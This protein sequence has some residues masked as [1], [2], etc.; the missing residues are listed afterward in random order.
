[1]DKLIASQ[2]MMQEGILVDR[3]LA[4]LE[5]IHEYLTA[6]VAK[7]VAAVAAD[8]RLNNPKKLARFDGLSDFSKR[9]A[10]GYF[11][12]RRCVE[13]HQSVAQEDI[14]LCALRQKLFIDDVEVTRLPARV[15]G[16]QH[17]SVRLEP[18]EKA[19]PADRRVVL[20]P[21]D[22]YGVV[23]TLL[24]VASEIFRLQVEQVQ[25]VPT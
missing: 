2:T 11:A 16:G 12:L 22:V 8:N 19:F 7:K 20:S 15:S 21:E 24:A 25:A 18:E 13:H 9:A 6:Y 3:N 23:L 10:L 5:E 14:Q 1:M 4:T 17:V